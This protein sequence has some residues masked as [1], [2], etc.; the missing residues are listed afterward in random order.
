MP[1]PS[2]T[3]RALLVFLLSAALPLAACGAPAP[4]PTSVP[5]AA[6]SATPTSGPPAPSITSVELDRAELPRYES[7]EMTVALQAQYT[8]PYDAREVSLDGIFTGPDGTQMTVPGFWDGKDSWRVRFTPSAE[9]EWR[10]QLTVKDTGGSSAPSEGTFNVTASD[11]HGWLQVGKTV[12]PA[13][14]ARYLA[15]HDGMPF[16]GVGHADA[17]TLFSGGFDAQQGF[18]IFNQMQKAGENYVVW[19]PLY[20]NSPV[21]PTYNEYSIPNMGVLDLIVRDAEKK[22]IFLVFTIWD[23]AQLRDSTHAWGP[24]QWEANGFSKLTSIKDFFVS[25]ES[26]VWQENFYRYVIARWGYS[27]A[28]GM[29]QTVSEINGTNAYDQT[30]SW[31]EKVNAYFIANDPYRHPTT[32]SKSGDVEWSEGHAAMDA[33]QVHLYDFKLGTQ[34]IDAV[35]SAAVIARWTQ[36]M[37]DVAEKPNWIGE[38]GADGSTYYPE[39]FH[40]SIWAALASGAA[41]T[42]AEWN[43]GRSWGEMTKEMDADIARLAAFVADIPLVK[44]D[45]ASLAIS[46]SDEQVRGWGVAGVEGGVLWVQDFALEGKTIDEVRADKT[47]RSGVQLE[48]RGLAAGTYLVTP[49]DTWQGQ[50]LESFEIT[51]TDGQ[52]CPVALPDFHAD[53]AFKL[54]RK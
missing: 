31:H 6:P 34:K 12:D 33:P 11:L 25:D 43:D 13:Y 54:E 14:S 19:W 39:M 29:W 41:M 20:G 28:I 26:W 37:W 16:Y 45:P 46:A 52:T 47:I 53:L 2:K 23:H 22:G 42:P 4:T 35:H 24:G 5:I 44:L 48:V 36:L 1:K 50:Y 27:R 40:N 49:Y 9:G 38:F 51:C 30:N 3:I 10:Y 7:L 17:I 18:S 32:A 21:N 15:H 8:N